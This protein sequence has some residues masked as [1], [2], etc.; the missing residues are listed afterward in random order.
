MISLSRSR[1]L[2]D[3]YAASVA[4]AAVIMVGVGAV[5]PNTLAGDTFQQQHFFF[6]SNQFSR[7]KQLVIYVASRMCVHAMMLL[8]ITTTMTQKRCGS[9]RLTTSCSQCI[10]GWMDVFCRD[11]DETNFKILFL[12]TR[13]RTACGNVTARTSSATKSSSAH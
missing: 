6:T 1:S 2:V 4:A 13:Q 11:E 8:A 9:C 5:V 12:L 3:G 10:D 7:D